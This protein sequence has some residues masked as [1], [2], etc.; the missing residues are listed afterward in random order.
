MKNANDVIGP[1][2]QVIMHYSITLEDGTVADSTFEEDPLS[3]VYGDGTL[4]DGLELAIAGLP[5]GA[6]QTLSI[7][8]EVGFGYHDP[9]NIHIMPPEAF[10]ESIEVAVGQVIGFDTPS[11]EEI[12]GMIKAVEPGEITVD[13]NH[14]LAG[15][16][17][18][19]R[20]AIIRVDNNPSDA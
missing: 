19:F 5:E 9:Q 12:P 20:V 2:S 4:Q 14:P 13:F 11:G 17:I 8:P 16:E 6:T 3:F 15:H 7:G 1:G 10:P 18:S